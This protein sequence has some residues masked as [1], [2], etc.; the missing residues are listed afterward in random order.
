M[1]NTNSPIDMMKDHIRRYL[2]SNGEDGHIMYG[3]P[4]LILSTTG[5]KSGEIRQV[6]LIYGKH[7]NNYVVMGS[8]G[9]SDIPPAW[10]QNLCANPLAHIQVKAEKMAVKMRVAEGKERQM[11]WGIMTA[12]FPDYIEYQKKTTR[13]LPVVVL[14]PA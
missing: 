6:A 11:L 1:S 8:K 3:S 10:Y 12:I 13:E 2:A 9:G 14:E 4:C 5:K 7:G